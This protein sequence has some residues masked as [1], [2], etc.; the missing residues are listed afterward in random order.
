MLDG[1]RGHDNA[2]HLLRGLCSGLAFIHSLQYVHCDIKPSNI[3]L[4]TDPLSHEKAMILAKLGDFGI[5]K[6]LP[7]SSNGAIS[8]HTL[9]NSALGSFGWMA[10][11]LLRSAPTKTK[12]VDIYSLG[13]VFHYVLTKGYHPF[14]REGDSWFDVCLKM[15][16]GRPDLSLLPDPESHL[17]VEGML[18]MEPPKRQVITEIPN[19]PMFWSTETKARFLFDFGE[20]LGEEQLG[21]DADNDNGTYTS[22]VTMLEGSWVKSKLFGDTSKYPKGADT[23]WREVLRD[24]TSDR[25]QLWKHMQQYTF[26]SERLRFLVRFVRNLVSHKRHI[27]KALGPVD[28]STDLVGLVLST[29][30]GLCVCCH[31]VVCRWCADD[32]VFRS[33]F[34]DCMQL[35]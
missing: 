28:G 16:Q 26:Y 13:C 2:L 30:P 10:P 21:K 14:L 1:E 23:D 6:H 27:L 19:N 8:M 4:K 32:F 18:A 11:E 7:D 31:A 35:S 29:F 25:T 34:S 5:A 3:L 9:E 24:V 15:G 20:Y 22:V 17:L 12:A 33:Y